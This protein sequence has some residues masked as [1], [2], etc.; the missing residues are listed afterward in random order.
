MKRPL[1]IVVSLSLF[2]FVL[3]NEPAPPKTQQLQPTKLI[4]A[5]K[6]ADQSAF[7]VKGK[8]GA[9]GW[10]A[11]IG[12]WTIV[13]GA[14][15]E[16]S[17]RPSEKRPNG[18][19]AVCEVVTDLGDLVLTGEFKLGD[20]PQV[21]FVCRD[22]NQPNHHLGRVVITP[23]AIWI[24][25]MSGIAKETRREELTRV[26]AEIDPKAWHTVTVEVS[27]DRW[28]ARIDDITLEAQH[29]RFADRKGRVGMVA[30]GDGAQ[31]RNLALWDAKQPEAA[32]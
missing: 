30:R 19:E 32:K 22:T 23:K 9:N 6:F 29:E 5:E 24:Q 10:R 12:E 13:D 18:H 31:F 28:I 2:S 17:E 14:A 21:G 25:K 16:K 8:P 11:G 15:Y 7:G 4:S 3:A 27:G 20:S 1:A 26:A